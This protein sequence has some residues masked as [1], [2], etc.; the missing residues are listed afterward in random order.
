MTLTKGDIALSVVCVVA[1]IL[2]GAGFRS[3]ISKPAEPAPEPIVIHDTLTITDT[4]RIAEHSRPVKPLQPDTL[5]FKPDTVRDSIF[6]PIPITAYE[7]RDTFQTDTS[8][9]ELG[10]HYE[11]YKAKID[12]ID[13]NYKSWIE[14]P[15]PVVKKQRFTWSLSF[16]LQGGYGAT[17]GKN[18]VVEMR[19]YTGV[20]GT[21]G[22][23]IN[24]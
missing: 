1:G 19:P 10:I 17:F 12:S 24:F 22:F 6:V 21:L 8:R 16:G 18:G 13:L 14:P 2:L 4:L 7:Y 11:G 3:C 23:S 15:K 20:G 5:W 9:I